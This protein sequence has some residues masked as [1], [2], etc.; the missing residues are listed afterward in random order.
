M[1]E[2]KNLSGWMLDCIADLDLYC[3]GFAGYYLRSGAER[4]QVIAAAMSLRPLPSTD[5]AKSE[6]ATF[7]IGARHRTILLSTFDEVPAGFR[8]ALGRSGHQPHP[9]QFYRRLH[10]MLLRPAHKRIVPTIAQMPTIDPIS[11][12]IARLLP[13]EI[14]SAKMVDIID[15]EAMASDVASLID[16]LAANGIDRNALTAAISRVTSGPSLAELWKRWSRKAV[17]PT[18]PVPRS[19]CYQPISTGAELHQLGLR[20]HN[21]AERY[22]AA[23]LD[24]LSSF[25]E[26]S[27]GGKTAVVHLRQEGGRWRAED[28]LAAHNRCVTSQL[29]TAALDHLSN[30]GVEG[31]PKRAAEASQWEV[32][33]RLTRTHMFEL[34]FE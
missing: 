30:F 2:T 6:L 3:P 7:L 16:L 14:C 28:I 33:R 25:G 5:A 32:L 31:R 13:A 4:R 27:H 24:Q 29:Q 9:R 17:F 15:S 10:A 20:Y 26:F 1:T 18:S 22:V 8:G 21:C 34:D 23:A 12:R 19:E 11:L